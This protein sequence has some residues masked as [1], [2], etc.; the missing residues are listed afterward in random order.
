MPFA[1]E[2]F[3]RTAA[4]ISSFSDFFIVRYLVVSAVSDEKPFDV[5]K[6]SLAKE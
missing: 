6:A 3:S 5:L 2:I 4:T 1:R